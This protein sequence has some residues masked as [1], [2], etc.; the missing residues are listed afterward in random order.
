MD[1]VFLVVFKR[2]A[3]ITRLVYVY[4]NLPLNIVSLYTILCH[5]AA[6]RIVFLLHAIWR[7]ARKC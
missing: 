5:Q 2:T 3:Q 4:Q 7:T 6:L 1:V